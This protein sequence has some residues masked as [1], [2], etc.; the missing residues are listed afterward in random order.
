MAELPLLQYKTKPVY[1]NS[2]H[3]YGDLAD[4]TMD[5]IQAIGM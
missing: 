3:P 5:Q 1:P 2:V 4:P